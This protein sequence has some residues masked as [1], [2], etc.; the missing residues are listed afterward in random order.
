V[1]A[2][3]IESAPVD[4]WDLEALAAAYRA[5]V[6]DAGSLLDGADG[7]EGDPDR[8]AFAARFHLVHEWRKFLFTDPGLPPELLPDEWAGHRAAE[9]FTAEAT[10]L[11]PAADRYVARCLD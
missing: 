7:E 3:A 5:F 9:L 10:R 11:K 4:A 2:D 8:A 1:R 6:D